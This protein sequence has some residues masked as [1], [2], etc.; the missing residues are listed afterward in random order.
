MAGLSAVDRDRDA[1]ERRGHLGPMLAGV[2]LPT[3][4]SRRLAQASALAGYGGRCDCLAGQQGDY[5]R[6][7]ITHELEKYLLDLIRQTVNPVCYQEKTMDPMKINIWDQ[8]QL[9]LAVY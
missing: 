2:F 9:I 8:L 7:R 5:Q 3:D 6:L 1:I 4:N